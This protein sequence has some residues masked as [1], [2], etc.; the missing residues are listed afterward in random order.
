MQHIVPHIVAALSILGSLFAFLQLRRKKRTRVVVVYLFVGGGGLG[1]GVGGVGG[2]GV[3]GEGEWGWGG[4]PKKFSLVLIW[5]KLAPKEERTGCRLFVWGGGGRGP[6]LSLVS[7]FGFPE[8]RQHVFVCSAKWCSC[9]FP[10]K[11]ASRRGARKKVV[12]ISYLF[13]RF[14]IN[15]HPMYHGP[16]HQPA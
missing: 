14:P 6:Q 7:S 13:S 8:T 11:P 3:E 5:S 12:E 15:G 1:G 9:G 16:F 10:F 2:G 4:G